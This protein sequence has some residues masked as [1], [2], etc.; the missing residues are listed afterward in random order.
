M[1]NELVRTSS[2]FGSPKNILGNTKSDL[3]L[4]SLGKIYVKTGK[5]TKVLND[6][7]KLLDKNFS[8]PVEQVSSKAIITSDLKSLE[9][10][11][12]GALVYDSKNKALYIAY[13]QRY[14]LILDNIDPV[15][16]S[17]GY[18]KKKGDSMSGQL[19][20]KHMGAPLIVASSE[21]VQNFNANYLEGHNSD[22]FAAK[23]LD[24]F[25]TGCWTFDQSTK[26]N[27]SIDV[28]TNAIVR[29]NV[30]VGNDV[31][32]NG[33]IHSEGEIKTESN[34][35]VEKNAAIKR[36][37]ILSGSIGSPAFMSGYN[38]YGWRFDANTNMLTVDYLVVRKAMQVFE[39]VVNKISATNGS[40]WVTDS[41]EVEKVFP[42]RFIDV[43][44]PN[45]RAYIDQSIY[46]VPYVKSLSAV[47]ITSDHLANA[48]GSHG[49]YNADTETWEQVTKTFACPKYVCRFDQ[50]PPSDLD[51]RLFFQLKTKE[52][53]TSIN[54][55]VEPIILFQSQI[56]GGIEEEKLP[57]VTDTTIWY[58]EFPYNKIYIAEKGDNSKVLGEFKRVYEEQAQLDEG[59]NPLLDSEGNTTIIVVAKN[60]I[61][62]IEYSLEEDKTYVF[63]SV[64]YNT[65]LDVP[66]TLNP[67]GT[68]E[69][70]PFNYTD[71]TWTEY[72]PEQKVSGQ[73]WIK[74]TDDTIEIVTAPSN[75]EGIKYT[76]QD[77]FQMEFFVPGMYNSPVWMDYNNVFNLST[78]PTFL[79]AQM[80][81]QVQ[82]S[83]D[84]QE[85]YLYYKYFGIE[86]NDIESLYPEMY[87]IRVKDD[88]QPTLKEGDLIRC[89]KF[90]NN[91]IRYY[92]AVVMAQFDTYNY[93]IKV[94]T[95]VFDRGTKVEYDENGKLKTYEEFVD[96]TMY[97]KT[98]HSVNINESET[99]TEKQFKEV[100]DE[101]PLIAAVQPKDG[102][103]RIGNLWDTNRQNSVYITSSES[104]S[105]YIRTLS[106]INRPDYTV[107]W[108]TP[109]FKQYTKLFRLE[110]N[111]W[112]IHDDY[113]Q[114]KLCYYDQ[115]QY[116]YV[117]TPNKNC[118]MVKN[119]SGLYNTKYNVNVRVQLGNLEGIID[120]MFK[121]KQPYG[122]GLFADNVFLKGEFYLNNGKTVVE[123]TKDH[124]ALEAQK[125]A[126]KA[127]A[128]N[129]NLFYAN[130]GDDYDD[131]FNPN[132]LRNTNFDVP[133]SQGNM[134]YW[135]SYQYK[136]IIE[137]GYENR[138]NAL[139]YTGKSSEIIR[140]KIP[141]KIVKGDTITISFWAKGTPRAEAKTKHFGFF[142]TLP[143][144]DLIRKSNGNGFGDVG[145]G[146]NTDAYF[147]PNE[148]WTFYW[149][150][151]TFD[152]LVDS[153]QSYAANS[154]KLCM[155]N[156][157][158]DGQMACLKLEKGDQ[159]TKY[160]KN[161]YDYVEGD[162]STYAQD[163]GRWSPIYGSLQK[164][165]IVD[166]DGLN[167][168]KGVCASNNMIQ[169]Q[170]ISQKPIKLVKNQSIYVQ[171]ECLDDYSSSMAIGICYIKQG[172]E[173]LI[174]SALKPVRQGKF[175]HKFV[176]SDDMD[177]SEYYLSLRLLIIPGTPLSHID[178][179][180]EIVSINRIDTEASITIENGEIIQK[181][182]GPGGVNEKM[183][184]IEGELNT[185]TDPNTGKLALYKQT[186]DENTSKIQTLDGQVSEISQ[187]VD[188]IEM[189]VGKVNILREQSS[190]EDENEDLWYA[191]NGNVYYSGS[192]MTT[193]FEATMD[194]DPASPT[195]CESGLIQKSVIPITKALDTY[196]L[197]SIDVQTIRGSFQVYLNDVQN[198]GQSSDTVQLTEGFQ[199]F[200]L[201][202]SRDFNNSHVYFF[203]KGTNTDDKIIFKNARLYLDGGSSLTITQDQITTEVTNK[204]SG[205]Q[206]YIDQKAVNISLGIKDGL[207]ET[208]I[209]IDSQ[210]ITL[211]GNT[212]INGKIMSVLDLHSTNSGIKFGETF[213]ISP[214]AT[215]WTSSDVD[216]YQKYLPKYQRYA[217]AAT[218]DND[219]QITIRVNLSS[220]FEGDVYLHKVEFVDAYMN[221]VTGDQT[222]QFYGE[223]PVTIPISDF[224]VFSTTGALNSL[225]QEQLPL[226]SDSGIDIGS[227]STGKG[228]STVNIIIKYIGTKYPAGTLRSFQCTNN[229]GWKIR[230]DY[231][232]RVSIGQKEI[233]FY[234][235]NYMAHFKE[236]SLELVGRSNSAIAGARFNPTNG[237]MVLPKT[238]HYKTS[239]TETYYEYYTLKEY[240]KGVQSGSL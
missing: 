53:T 232:P 167:F 103:V 41:V 93:V 149:A 54:D 142:I 50:I 218:F 40:L 91:S 22:Y 67:D 14:L 29:N 83:S 89:Q 4:E 228:A 107:L 104:N 24:E 193:T 33:K 217:A 226:N 165:E 212:K 85:I 222:F 190:V 188:G 184:T 121:N 28:N 77:Y 75:I 225:V 136:E 6:L 86:Y 20:I 87:V 39:L 168:I 69:T 65:Y 156:W 90:E 191:R 177:D 133:N 135:E 100:Y 185:I 140:A 43:Y 48:N 207:K 11:H 72:I 49:N 34:L 81:E 108:S 70:A 153:V 8:E 214:D 44:D 119:D 5:Q 117:F 130:S 186:I 1:Q 47:Q 199:T 96:R 179:K 66:F 126:L 114:S 233:L 158:Y 238:E 58:D 229:I 202:L 30:N 141:E 95:S 166:S 122:Y 198:H 125:I 189:S 180:K 131:Y 169:F 16:D 105:P 124:V 57:D 74:Y 236:D 9:Y 162:P 231:K 68:Y 211:N 194:N 45:Y 80:L 159:A 234:N 237:L 182:E 17:I 221:P 110:N 46:Y 52:S 82:G 42:V 76:V 12:D 150:T 79:S 10:P 187:T 35:V 60:Y 113:G 145:N 152:P 112:V 56:Q 239:D 155:Y 175:Q 227:L 21:L 196:L 25:I 78:T 213:K 210:L 19:T 94:A 2:L 195:K 15:A 123:F 192:A 197:G 111:E 3:I 174:N 206:S 55:Y 181:L 62:D 31:N 120:P 132:I 157:G 223:E 171:L 88:T 71:L 98:D 51:P 32:V 84:L 127:I 26:F 139:D 230:I 160:C 161:Y 23:S 92:D 200:R 178:F 172:T 129:D 116:K 219:N 73:V 205:L 36:D 109:D 64:L 147:S 220:P 201:R 18:V 144:K 59:G 170:T 101:D 143:C 183:T 203:I 115:V 154:V 209:D 99:L 176:L 128:K 37:I 102:L 61:N 235:N 148:D 151:F 63:A 204:T 146:K 118:E 164:S 163:I 106:Q 224:Q 134:S 216:L 38:G 173:C 13:Q 7:F 27:K 137:K 215:N 138:F 97:D 240:I 208:G